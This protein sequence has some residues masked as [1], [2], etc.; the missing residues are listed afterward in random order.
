VRDGGHVQKKAL[1]VA[2]G[3]PIS[4][5]REV[6]G[7]WAAESEGAELWLTVLT[8]LKDRG[9]TGPLLCLL[10]RSVGFRERNLRAF[11]AAGHRSFPTR[12]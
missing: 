12:L 10:R 2:F 7:L 8:E 5:K 1:Y 4:G 9:V 11:D 6:L 3:V